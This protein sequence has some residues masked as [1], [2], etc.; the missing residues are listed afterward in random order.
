MRNLLLLTLNINLWS[1][2]WW[3]TKFYFVLNVWLTYNKVALDLSAILKKNPSGYLGNSYSGTVVKHMI[4]TLEGMCLSPTTCWALFSSH[5]IL[6][7]VRSLTDPSKSYKTMRGTLDLISSRWAK[8]FF[9]FFF[10]LPP[11]PCNYLYDRITDHRWR[12]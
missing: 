7:A 9:S 6:S 3:R 10:P 11:K 4:C 2:L 8:T 5:S 1:P 12:G